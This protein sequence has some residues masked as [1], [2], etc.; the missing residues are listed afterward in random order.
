MSLLLESTA[1][2]DKDTVG[3]FRKKVDAREV[4]RRI[5]E[6]VTL[7]SKWGF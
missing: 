1:H 5:H 3:W 2:S 7:V 6:L 4:S